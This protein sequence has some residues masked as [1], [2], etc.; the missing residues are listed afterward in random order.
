MFGGSLILWIAFPVAWIWVGGQIQGATGSVAAALGAAMLGF[1]VSI[2]LFFPA[3]S[4]L[5]DKHREQRVARGLD[6]TGHL[7]LEAVMVTS[8]GLAVVLFG[9]WFL[10]LSGSSP[11]PLKLGY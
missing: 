6:D 7:A 9:A 8:A 3:L 2:A 10:V 5:S 11:I 1:V 4:W